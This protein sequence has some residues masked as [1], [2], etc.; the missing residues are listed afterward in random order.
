MLDRESGLDS[1][2]SCSVV[3]LKKV[4]KKCLRAP[5]W[6]TDETDVERI[7]DGHDLRLSFS[8]TAASGVVEIL[9]CTQ[10][11]SPDWLVFRLG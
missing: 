4:R 10:E 6:S 1:R 5:I 11:Y 2:Y 7:F 9:K 8:A 3:F